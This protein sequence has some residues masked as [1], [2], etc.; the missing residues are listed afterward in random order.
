MTNLAAPPSANQKAY[1]KKI[2]FADDDDDLEDWDDGP[3]K[4]KTP[5]PPA[6]KK[7]EAGSEDYDDDDWDD[8]DYGL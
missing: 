6:A 7:E 4:G 1:G 2:G 3:G 8:A 5:A